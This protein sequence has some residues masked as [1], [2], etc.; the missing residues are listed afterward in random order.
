MCSYFMLQD[1]CN[2]FTLC[3][4]VGIPVNNA[5]EFGVDAEFQNSS[6]VLSDFECVGEE[7]R[8]LDC[9]SR[10]VRICPFTTPVGVICRGQ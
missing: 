9:R 7:D 3:Y 10:P 6:F 5:R 1:G 2:V 4:T 8:L